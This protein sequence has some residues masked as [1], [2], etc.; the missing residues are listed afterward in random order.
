[1]KKQYLWIIGLMVVGI[2]VALA[3]CTRQSGSLDELSATVQSL[4]STLTSI[5]AQI[6]RNRA[7]VETLERSVEA[8]GATDD[9]QTTGVVSGNLGV[10]VTAMQ[11]DLS[12]LSARVAE[13]EIYI[14]EMAQRVQQRLGSFGPPG[15]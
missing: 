11:E 5:R 4:D 6:A 1:M 3:G 9:T 12:D 2:A 15:G 7:Q 14:A 10:L 8:L 13:I